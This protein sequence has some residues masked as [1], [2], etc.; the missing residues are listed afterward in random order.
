[1]RKMCALTAAVAGLLVAAE[2][3]RDDSA[4]AER[5]K[6]QGTWKL[7]SAQRDGREVS[8]DGVGR[9]TLIIK[10]DTFRFPEETEVGTGPHGTFTIDPT[11]TPKAIDATP[12]SG[13]D[14]GKTSRGV[15]KIEGDRYEVHFAPPGEGRPTELVP[16]ASSKGLHSVWK[17]AG[18]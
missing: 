11:A 5:E 18:P 15:Y 3:P 2:T 14:K 4:K 16:K 12:A 17:R 7:V 13:P 6:F 9:T 10:G 1:M 8:K